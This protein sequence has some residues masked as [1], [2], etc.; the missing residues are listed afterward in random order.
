MIKP[1][2]A[3]VSTL[4]QGARRSAPTSRAKR[5]AQVV[6]AVGAALSIAAAFGPIWLIRAGIALALLAGLAATVLLLRELAATRTRHREELTDASRRAH[7][8]MKAERVRERE[9]LDV[10][11]VR[12]A[13]LKSRIATLS[14]DLETSRAQLQDAVATLASTR[15]TLGEREELLSAREETIEEMRARVVRLE[16][17]LAALHAHAETDEAELLALPRRVE[18][19]AAPEPELEVKQA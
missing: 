12:T 13:A 4:Q 7:E 17:E 5:T 8:A 1:Y 14:S 6:L 15:V 2:D 10:I 16:D 11:D 18:R 19:E 9:V 3:G